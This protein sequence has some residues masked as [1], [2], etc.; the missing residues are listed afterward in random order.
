MKKKHPELLS[1]LHAA[2]SQKLEVRM[3]EELTELYTGLCLKE[4]LDFLDKLDSEQ[5]D[6]S[7]SEIVW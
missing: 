1:N 3:K 5:A 2:F 6:M 7:Q 4:K